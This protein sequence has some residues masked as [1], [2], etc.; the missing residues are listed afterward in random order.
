MT[1]FRRGRQIVF[2]I[3]N[4]TEEDEETF[5]AAI[6]PNGCI[7]Y[8]IYGHEE[9]GENEVYHLQGYAQFNKAL[10][11]TA[12]KKIFPRAHIESVKGTTKQAIDYCK[13]EGY[14]DEFGELRT[15]GK[16]GSNTKKYEEIK[17]RIMIKNDPLIKVIVDCE[18]TAQ[19]RFAET[20][21]KY[22]TTA[23]HFEKKEVYWYFGPTG[24]GK[25]RCAFES[26]DKKDYWVSSENLKWFDGYS[27]QKDAIFDDFRG[28]FATFHFLL[29][30]L[31]GYPLKVPVKGGFTR[32][33]PKRIFITCPYPPKGVYQ[34]VEDKKQLY[35]RLTQIR[36]FGNSLADIMPASEDYDV[37]HQVEEVE[38]IVM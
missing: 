13:K 31:D 27:G 32:W 17:E 9:E 23:T 6:E 29:R 12:V 1:D 38:E 4:P 3:N 7:N 10:T 21:E 35:R 19:I 20:I 11:L 34:G 26:V 30:L 36:Y 28:D 22:T 25:S 2:T 14:W 18:N 5:T 33:C 8:I 24:C 37:H 16:K 15:Q